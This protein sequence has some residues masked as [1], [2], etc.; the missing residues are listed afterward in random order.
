LQAGGGIPGFGS[1]DHIP[2]IAE[3]GEFMIR[4]A[5]A[6]K[7]G[8]AMLN[9][10]NHADKYASGGF[11]NEPTIR[12]STTQFLKEGRELGI[13]FVYLN[14]VI[15]EVAQALEG[16][17][18]PFK[19]VEAQKLFS[20]ALSSANIVQ[21]QIAVS[22]RDAN[23][24]RALVTFN[25]GI[26]LQGG[27]TSGGSLPYIP[28]QSRSTSL[29]PYTT[30]RSGRFTV[31]AISS[32]VLSSEIVG[33]PPLRLTDRRPRSLVPY[34]LGQNPS[35]IIG[36]DLRSDLGFDGKDLGIFPA[37]Y[38]GL[39]DL[40][41]EMSAERAAYLAYRKKP[42]S[43]SGRLR[44]GFNRARSGL[45]ELNKGFDQKFGGAQGLAFTSFL[46]GQFLPQLG[47]PSAVSDTISGALGGA[48]A[49]SFIGGA[50]GA[51]A[52][53][54]YGGING[55]VN[56]N[57]QDELL[58]AQKQLADSSKNLDRAFQN[59]AKNGIAAFSSAVGTRLALQEKVSGIEN[60]TFTEKLGAAFGNF[61][62]RSLL[63]GRNYRSGRCCCWIRNRNRSCCWCWY[64]YR[65]CNTYRTWNSSRFWCIS[66]L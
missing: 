37:G 63:K 8:P 52:G 13:N 47:V 46:A 6:Q 45:R 49:G 64:C 48:A 39:D 42:Q 35:V 65:I 55:L 18:A 26:G 44:R 12:E 25:N 56:N 21:N 40:T 53:A 23:L 29:V 20:G 2:I 24:S 58:K 3:P 28:G 4:K 16:V 61:D 7:L 43:S 38:A 62:N 15:R 51:I 5:A 30:E 36:K 31:N 33:P 27:G 54:V 59:I 19:R 34:G 41:S 14:K 22:K 1:G 66:R 9:R 60:R 17:A 57:Q 11:I 32:K 50:P 10:L